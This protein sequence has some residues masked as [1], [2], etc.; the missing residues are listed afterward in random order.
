MK[1]DD[2]KDLVSIGL[3][4]INNNEPILTEAGDAVVG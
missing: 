1:E 3:V 2:L 4:E